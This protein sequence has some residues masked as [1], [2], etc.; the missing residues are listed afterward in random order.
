MRK[1]F[2]RPPTVPA[3]IQGTKPDIYTLDE[4]DDLD[5]D[6]IELNNTGTSMM[7]PAFTLDTLKECLPKNF[8]STV[9]NKLLDDV[10][11]LVQDD[12]F[13]AMYRENLVTFQ[14]VLLNGKYTV[15]NYID[16][17]SFCSFKF[18]GMTDKDAYAHAFPERVKRL[19]DAGK[20][21]KT[22]SAYVCA[23]AKGKLVVEL[24]GQASIPNYLL[25]RD[26]FHKAVMTQAR[27]MNTA[28]SE[29][30]QTQ[31]ANSLLVALKQPDVSKMQISATISHEGISA[32]DSLAQATAALVRQQRESIIN[33]STGAKDVAEARIVDAEYVE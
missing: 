25:Y 14:S 31:A 21:D 15:D 11:N 16:A 1:P 20:N 22:I 6:S 9:T 17:V 30:V 4:V 33:G 28:A 3:Q 24:L 12:E 10:N 5:E 8:H 27:L 26:V 2:R 23:Y 29:L 32:I 18:M 13:A 19:K 7:A